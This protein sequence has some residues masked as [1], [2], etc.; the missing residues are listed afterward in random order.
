MAT[1]GHPYITTIVA[2][3]AC[4]RASSYQR[5]ASHFR[6][7]NCQGAKALIRIFLGLLATVMMMPPA[8]SQTRPVRSERTIT[9]SAY[10]PRNPFVAGEKLSYDVSWADFIVAGELTIQTDDRRSFDGIDGYHVTAQARSVGLVSVLNLKVNDVYD[11]FINPTTLQPFR[12]EK[13]SRHGK[14]QSQSS[15]TIDQQQRSARLSDG[16]TVEIPADT[17][18]LAGLIFAMRGMDLTIGKPHAFT[19]LEDDKLYTIS[20][21]PEAKEKITTRAGSYDT[22]RLS[23]NMKRGRENDKLYNLRMYITN[24]AR[25]MP[26]LITAEPSWGSVRV[27]LTSAT[28]SATT[29]KKP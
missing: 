18:D 26:V 20:V 2:V 8:M 13:H 23:T 24:D 5:D 21:Q 11:S 1:E 27:E 28:T 25:R 9:P 22:I 29:S 4:F 12:A 10:A 3:L 7:V 15:V 14:K 17:Y 16:R 19:I 6:K